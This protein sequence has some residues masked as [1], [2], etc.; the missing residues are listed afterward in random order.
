MSYAHF[1]WD[2]NLRFSLLGMIRFVHGVLCKICCA[3][4]VH[5][6]SGE[7][8]TLNFV[9]FSLHSRSFF[10]QFWSRIFLAN[11]TIW[12]SNLISSRVWF[13]RKQQALNP[14]PQISEMLTYPKVS[15]RGCRGISA[16]AEYLQR[17][18]K[19]LC[20]SRSQHVFHGENLHPLRNAAQD[21]VR[22]LLYN[23]KTSISVDWSA[24]RKQYKE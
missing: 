15:R 3:R 23:Q 6:W 4:W 12:F 17:T 24:P 7:L 18:A 1:W 10:F 9:G 20:Y 16:S 5:W 21:R 11:D 22:R 8:V 13:F 19:C 2:W 14:M